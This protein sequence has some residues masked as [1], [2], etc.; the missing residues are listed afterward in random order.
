[1]NSN[2]NRVIRQGGR[3]HVSHSLSIASCG[4][5]AAARPAGSGAGVGV[6]G[7]EPGAGRPNFALY[8]QSHLVPKKLTIC[9]AGHTEVFPSFELF[10]IRN[11]EYI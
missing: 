7:A 4:A 3:A 5:R 8:Q 9:E 2:N 1:M 11:L 10:W 6:S